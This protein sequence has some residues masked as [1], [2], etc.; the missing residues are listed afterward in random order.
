M[1]NDINSVTMSGR[2]ATEPELIEF[3]TGQK[4][5]KLRIANNRYF[6]EAGN[7]IKKTTFIDAIT[8]NKLAEICYKYLKKGKA[9]VVS[10]TLEEFSSSQNKKFFCRTEI[11][12][13]KIIFLP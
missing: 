13:K 12:V 2:L 7:K 5:C 9:V 11:I 8:W 4:L 6:N 10:G 1:V 3:D